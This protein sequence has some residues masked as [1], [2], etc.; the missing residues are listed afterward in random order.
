M[1]PTALAFSFTILLIQLAKIMPLSPTQS[2]Q[3]AVLF[4]TT[5]PQIALV[6][7]ILGGNKVEGL[8][9]FKLLNFIVI[10]PAVGTFLPGNWEYALS[11]IPSYW[12]YLWILDAEASGLFWL[13][14]A[15]QLLFLW[16]LMVMFRK[17]VF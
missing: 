16:Y 12:I 3:C 14:L 17:K 2:I 13:A 4:S 7:T 15:I 9:I 6:M 11:V 10:L 5:A 8:A 1:L